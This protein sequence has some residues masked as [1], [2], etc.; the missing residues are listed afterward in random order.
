MNELQKLLS[1]QSDWL[2]IALTAG[3]IIAVA[4]IA[5]L[6]W[7]LDFEELPEDNIFDQLRMLE[8]R[9]EKLTIRAKELGMFDDEEQ[10][11][12]KVNDENDFNHRTG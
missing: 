11:I 7:I 2:I 1:E 4:V 6:L 12:E 9:T 8:S 10:P 5:V 3:F